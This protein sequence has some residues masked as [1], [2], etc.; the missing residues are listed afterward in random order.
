M[1][2]L[3]L[4]ERTV[5]RTLRNTPVVLILLLGVSL[6]LG[7][8]SRGVTLPNAVPPLEGYKD[9]ALSGSVLDVVSAERDNTDFLIYHS[10]RHGDFHGNRKMWCDTLAAALSGELSKRG[11]NILPSAATRFMLKLPEISGRSGYMAIGFQ[12]KAV[13]TSTAG[14]TKTYEGQA[15]AAEMG[16]TFETRAARAASSTIAELVKAMLADPE[17]ISQ[18]K[19]A[20]P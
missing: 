3:G 2:F 19:G 11:A 20:K 7:A 12:A 4:T 1:Y 15:S 6:S 8:C 16:T 5:E 17:F 9:L 14:W 18:I 10:A 13:V